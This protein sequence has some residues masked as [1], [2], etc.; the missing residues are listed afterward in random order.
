MENLNKFFYGSDDYNKKLEIFIKKVETINE[1]YT[2]E[3]K[4]DEPYYTLIPRGDKIY[5]N[6][7]NS[8]D[9]PADL[10]NKVKSAFNETW[11]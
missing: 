7:D 3:F 4:T 5:L 10:E 9:I 6:F 2:G 11:R 8:K 1:E